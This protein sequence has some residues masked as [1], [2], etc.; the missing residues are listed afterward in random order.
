MKIVLCVIA[1]VA[2]SVFAIPVR[3]SDWSIQRLPNGQQW[4]ARYVNGVWAE[5]KYFSED[6]R[7]LQHRYWDSLGRMR[8][9]DY[10]PE[11][12]KVDGSRVRE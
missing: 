3:Q 11:T 10:D 9:V 12:G 5:E 4:H 6:G 7:L 2:A 8:E 1:L